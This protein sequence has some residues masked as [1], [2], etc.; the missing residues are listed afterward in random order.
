M[1]LFDDNLGTALSGRGCAGGRSVERGRRGVAV[2]VG[3]VGDVGE[4]GTARHWGRG[5]EWELEEREVCL[6]T[7]KSLC[8]AGMDTVQTQEL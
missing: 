8:K 5:S 6:E 3:V 1:V 7:W 4:P 2:D